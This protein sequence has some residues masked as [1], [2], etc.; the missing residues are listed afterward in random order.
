[1]FFYKYIL[2]F[3]FTVQVLIRGDQIKKF[4]FASSD[5]PSIHFEFNGDCQS[6]TLCYKSALFGGNGNFAWK[7]AGRFRFDKLFIGQNKICHK[8]ERAIQISMKGGN[9]SIGNEIFRIDRNLSKIKVQISSLTTLYSKI[10]VNEDEKKTSIFGKEFSNQV[11]HGAFLKEYAGFWLMGV[12][13]LP[14]LGQKTT[15]ITAIT[16][17]KCEFTLIKKDEQHK[18]YTFDSEHKKRRDA[19]QINPLISDGTAID[20]KIMPWHVRFVGKIRHDNGSITYIMCGGSLISPEF[21]LLAAHCFTDLTEGQTFFIGFNSSSGDILRR[22][23]NGFMTEHRRYKSN[24][25]IHPNYKPLMA[26]DLALIKLNCALKG[27]TFPVCIHCGNVEKF[28]SG[29]GYISGWGQTAD[30]CKLKTKGSTELLGRFVQLI[31][32]PAY[33]DDLICIEPDSA[34]SGDSG[35]ALL[36]SNGT[37]FV[38]VGVLSGGQCTLWTQMN[39]MSLYVPLDGKWIEQITGVKCSN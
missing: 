23:N 31:D 11:M 8:N 32:C 36:A 3:F 24:V 35:G 38:Q 16:S 13:I 21:V 17:E 33:F 25:F 39:L 6:V 28:R 10:I 34:Q 1:M 27:P 9:F 19:R 7:I 12:D 22:V 4:E 37:H 2:I 20:I 15:K 14:K 5:P 29:I 26:F 30:D 18:C